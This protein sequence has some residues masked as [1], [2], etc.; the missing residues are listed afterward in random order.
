MKLLDGN[1]IANQ[2][3]DNV[4]LSIT[5]YKTKFNSSP[6]LSTILVGNNPASE[7]YINNKI[8][9]CKK[10]GILSHNIRLSNKISQQELIEIILNLNQDPTITGIL[11]QLPL[12]KHIPN[13]KILEQIDP[14]KDVDGLSP[15]SMGKL[16]YKIS[17]LNV[18]TPLGIIRLLKY[19]N[20]ENLAGKNVTIVG[21][22]IIVGKPLAI[23]LMDLQA[24][25]TICNIFTKDLKNK[26][27]DADILISA[28]GK[29][30]II[31]SSW[32]KPNVVAI[33]VGINRDEIGKIHGDLD[34]DTAKNIASFITPVPGGI[35]P[36]TIAILMENT[37]TAAKLQR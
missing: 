36:M 34:F 30:N 21:S 28:I 7:V 22:S 19:Y 4:K 27:K 11:I 17:A 3:L 2:L 35:G 25:V 12:P 5:E 26:I 20:L 18:C 33:D 16:C 14:L 1:K 13:H 32:L 24:T 8:E 9:A 10:V 37:L 31:D 23:M 15:L 6:K 29:R